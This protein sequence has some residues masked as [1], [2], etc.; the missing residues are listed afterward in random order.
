MSTGQGHGVLVSLALST[1]CLVQELVLLV[2][3][4]AVAATF[5]VLF[6]ALCTLRSGIFSKSLLVHGS[7]ETLDGPS[8]AL[9][10]ISATDRSI[11]WS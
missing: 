10:D 3:V 11:W 6:H 7:V 8:V 5:A 2:M 1:G 9:D 4:G